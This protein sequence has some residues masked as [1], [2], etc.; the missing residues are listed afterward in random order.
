M[1]K[2]YGPKASNWRGGRMHLGGGRIAVYAP[3]HPQA[4]LGGNG[5]THILEYRLIAEKLVGRRLK[6]N[7]IVHHK[8][9]DVTDNRL[10]N[11]AVMTQSEHAREH[12]KERRGING[13]FLS[14]SKTRRANLWKGYTY[15][16]CAC[17][18]VKTR[19][20]KYCSQGCYLFDRWG[21]GRKKTHGSQLR[22]RV[23]VSQT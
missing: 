1:A 10:S 12:A 18:K 20:R 15:I 4:N 9:G 8:N 6:P 7:E 23:K 11:L 19:Y 17:C 3:W 21:W 22:N 16:K 5:G 14:A 13:Q 2:R